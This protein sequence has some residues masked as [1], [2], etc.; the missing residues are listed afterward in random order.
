MAL[1]RLHEGP[2]AD[3]APK[4]ANLARA[5]AV[6]LPV[7]RGVVID[8]ADVE[9]DAND[10]AIVELW[11]AGPT[12]VRSALAVED[13]AL[14]SGA[15]LG[16]SKGDVRDVAALLAVVRE[17]RAAKSAVPSAI[18]GNDQIIVQ[19][20]ITAHAR[21]VVA[22]EPTRTYLE[23]YDAS[24]DA[25]GNGATPMFSGPLAS[26]PS[27]ARASTST[28]LDRVRATFDASLHGLD[29]ELVVDARGAVHLVQ[30]RPLT[31]P[32]HPGWPAFVAAVR[33]IGDEIPPTGVLVLDVE[34]NPDPLS[35]AHAWL[36]RWLTQERPATGG[37]MPLGGW[38]Y[39][40][41]L[42]RDLA[43][44]AEPTHES[45]RAVV[46][47]LHHDIIPAARTRLTSI[48]ARAAEARPNQIYDLFQEALAAFVAMIDIYLGV[49]VPARRDHAMLVALPDDPLCLRGRDDVLD[50]LPVAWDV[51]AP[52]L[53]SRGTMSTTAIELPDDD[54]TAATLLREWDDHLFALGLAPLRSVYLRVAALTGLGDDVFALAPPEC[55]GALARAD[56]R[57]VIERR[58]LARAAAGQLDPPGR[59]VDGEPAGVPPRWLR[60]LAIGPP[61]QGR[62]AQRRDLA[63]LRSDPPA[64]DSIVV[65]PALTAP[66]A[67]VLHELG[68]RAICCEHGGAL[69]H[70][71]LMARELRLSAL[72]GC[73]G[74]T[75]IPDG[76][77]VE[78]DTRRGVLRPAPRA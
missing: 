67:V 25:F 3:M 7:P 23:Q 15:G 53:G 12:I 1:P 13:G 44:H 30:V 21:I 34:H 6:G 48:A 37:L 68:L 39:T 9:R 52:T 10:E 24:I 19:H 56:L 22:C 11:R 69:S 32:L 41:V 61:M 45:A 35:F 20:E 31:A 64:P 27:D 4:A 76:T 75:T 46:A 49:L 42:I 17:I 40:R 72:L 54:A 59:I 74:C 71:A 60:G 78:L 26:W 43:T 28:L 14:H 73:R 58:R 51:A 77:R 63:H 50:V 29:V 57:G 55:I 18:A 70:A 2:R 62:I 33:A 5:A 66:A 16:V 38:L 36:V 65:L 47:R 8:L